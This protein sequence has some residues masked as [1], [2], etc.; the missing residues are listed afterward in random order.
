MLSTQSNPVSSVAETGI[1][2]CAGCG[3]PMRLACTEPDKP[4][5]RSAH[6]RMCNVQYRQNSPRCHLDRSVLDREPGKVRK[7]GCNQISTM[8]VGRSQPRGV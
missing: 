6:L 1:L 8:G 7:Y 2:N 5:F 3:K 4:G